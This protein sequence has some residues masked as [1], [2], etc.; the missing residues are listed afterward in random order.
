[1]QSE[2]HLA[3]SYGEQSIGISQEQRPQPVGKSQPV[4]TKAKSRAALFDT[5]TT[6]IVIGGTA[7]FIT[8]IFGLVTEIVTRVFD[9]ILLS[10]FI[11]LCFGVI[12]YAL[13]KDNE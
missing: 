9:N 7:Q 12:A 11:G 8:F 4:K 3:T 1:M 2:T 6:A 5:V 13:M 10:A